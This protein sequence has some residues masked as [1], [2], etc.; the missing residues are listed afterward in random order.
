MRVCAQRSMLMPGGIRRR[1]LNALVG[2]AI[3]TTFQ[4]L[5][6]AISSSVMK[7][8]L[9]SPVLGLSLARDLVFLSSLAGRF[10]ISFS[11]FRCGP[12]ML[13]CCLLICRFAFH[14]SI[15]NIRWFPALAVLFSD[16]LVKCSWHV[17]MFL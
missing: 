12:F 14:W 15:E 2:L 10:V 8:H 4:R 6:R 9:Y 11:V 17:A 1:F 7:L 13:I 5:I 3:A 16:P